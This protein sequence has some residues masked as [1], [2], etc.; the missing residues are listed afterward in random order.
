MGKQ[1]TKRAGMTVF[2]RNVLKIDLILPTLIILFIA[3]LGFFS[4]HKNSIITGNLDSCG[5]YCLMASQYGTMLMEQSFDKYY[6]S[7]SLGSLIGYLS[8]SILGFEKNPVTMNLALEIISAFAA[9][10]ICG[11]WWAICRVIH[12]PLKLFWLGIFGLFANQLFYW[13]IA[14][15]QETPDLLALF[16][17]IGFIYTFLSKLRKLQYLFFALTLFVQPQAAM[18]IVPMILFPRGRFHNGPSLKVSRQ[19]LLSIKNWFFTKLE[20][21]AY[22]KRFSTLAV[23]TFYAILFSLAGYI[24]PLIKLPYHGTGNSLPSLFIFSILLA[25]SLMS[26]MMI[27]LDPFESYLLFLRRLGAIQGLQTLSVILAIYLAK[28]FI[29]L[30]FAQGPVRAVGGLDGAAW[31]LYSFQY[32]LIEQPLKSIFAHMIYYGPVFLLLMFGWSNIKENI[33]MLD[34]NAGFIVSL[35]LVVLLIP[36]SE[37]RHLVAFLPWIMLAT[38]PS[39]KNIG[40]CQ[41]CVVGVLA[42]L[43]T[44][45]FIETPYVA[46]HSNDF[47]LM[48]WGP[49]WVVE[50]YNRAAVVSIL[51]TLL[52]YSARRLDFKIEKRKRLTK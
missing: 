25:L 8:A 43:S 23:I 18:F 6:F 41:I 29:V 37:S 34:L 32:Q 49:W 24:F 46:D 40:L 47:W 39:L 26:W 9:V 51:A 44:R 5:I 20:Y 45:F 22:D 19:E 11:F 3:L 21:I 2:E 33:K 27:K 17:G 14:L 28:S 12:F 52:F 30:Y 50:T 13:E 38:F 16:F 7:K 35:S 1:D 42:L 36:N 48:T 4:A 15:Q 10:G 31:I